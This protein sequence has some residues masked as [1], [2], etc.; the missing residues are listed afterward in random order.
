MSE[1]KLAV[2]QGRLSPPWSGRFQSFP[3]ESWAEE[4]GRAVVA[5]ID[6]IEWIHDEAG[7]S[8]NPLLTGSGRLEMTRLIQ[9]SGVAVHGCCLDLFMERPLQET[10]DFESFNAALAACAEVGIERATLPLVD[11]SSA[12]RLSDD[13]VAGLLEACGEVGVDR[14]VRVDVEFDLDPE[15]AATVMS[16]VGDVVGVTYDSGNSAG[17]GFEI[18]EEFAAYGQWVRSAHLKDRVRG[19]GTVPPGTGDADLPRFMDLLD[20][21]RVDG[22]LTLQVARDVD[23]DEVAWIRTIGEQVRALNRAAR[24][25]AAA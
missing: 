6:G 21:G 18:D 11:R 25:Q 1:L 10:S 16:R 20:L 15:R 12:A 13:E 9:Q 14:G 2:M 17:L 3:V 23:G 8:V 7:L 22:W 19:G 4:F 24:S 5:G